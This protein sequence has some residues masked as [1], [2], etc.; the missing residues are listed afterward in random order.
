MNPTTDNQYDQNHLEYISQEKAF[1]AL[2]PED[3]ILL[4]KAVAQFGSGKVLDMGCG[5]GDDVARLFSK[6]VD[7]HGV[8]GST[9]LI[10]DAKRAHPNIADRLSEGSFEKLPFESQV[11]DNIISRFA[12][13]YA[14]NLDPVFFRNAQSAKG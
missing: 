9:A 1:T 8:D 14:L 4:D 11:F 12:I 3:R 2:W 5:P 6:G 13:H 7:I 10:N